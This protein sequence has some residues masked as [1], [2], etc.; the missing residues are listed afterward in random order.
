MGH[1]CHYNS[2]SL[3]RWQEIQAIDRD[4][5]GEYTPL[6]TEDLKYIEI[7]LSEYAHWWFPIE[8]VAEGRKR[9]D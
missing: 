7:N 8:F 6:S 9:N 2:V 5:Y 3:Q 1:Y 4:K